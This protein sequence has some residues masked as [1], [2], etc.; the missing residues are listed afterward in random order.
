MTFSFCDGPE[1]LR[2]HPVLFAGLFEAKRANMMRSEEYEGDREETRPGG[3]DIADPMSEPFHRQGITSSLVDS[4]PRGGTPGDTF[5]TG[6]S[7]E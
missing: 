5:V 2:R 3:T 1:K 6:C 4:G 7:T